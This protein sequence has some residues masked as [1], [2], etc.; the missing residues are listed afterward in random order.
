MRAD[1]Q[2]KMYHTSPVKIK[3]IDALGKFGEV[4]F[5]SGDVYVMTASP[6]YYIYSVEISQDEIIEVFRFKYRE[7]ELK[8][9]I[10][11]IKELLDIDEDTALELLCGE[12]SVW[13]L[14]K[15][16]DLA[17]IAWKIQE[18]QGMSA[19][20]LGYFAAES[21]DEQGTVYIVP[22]LEKEHLLKIEGQ[23]T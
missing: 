12:K 19:K 17:D 22:M 3:K 10:L 8:E 11:E 9:E 16:E 21:E 23:R 1:K 14:D 6:K 15:C 4:L 20:K 13:Q 2:L 7:S 5:F 18:L